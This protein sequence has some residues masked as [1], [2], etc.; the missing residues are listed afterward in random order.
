[1][2]CLQEVI[3]SQ[4]LRLVLFFDSIKFKWSSSVI[5]ISAHYLNYFHNSLATEPTVLIVDFSI[6][7]EL[8]LFMNR[9]CA[10]IFNDS[11]MGRLKKTTNSYFIF[12]QP[13]WR[14]KG[15][16]DLFHG[17]RVK[18]CPCHHISL[19]YQLFIEKLIIGS[20]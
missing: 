1:M 20:S 19:F 3:F 2:K 10:V 4:L 14:E 17:F 16:L 11:W 7:V 9:T 5:T 12:N 18:L 6:W 15:K 8:Q 13:R